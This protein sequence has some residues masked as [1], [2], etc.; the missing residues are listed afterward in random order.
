MIASG[1]PHEAELV[2]ALLEDEFAN[3]TVALTDGAIPAKGEPL[4]FGVLIL[5]YKHLAAAEQAY[6]GLLRR[7]EI[8]D[9]TMHRSVVFCSREEVADTYSLC[10]QG[11][12]DD[13]VVFWPA[14]FDIKRL[15]MAVH[16]ALKQ[17]SAVDSGPA[18][19]VTGCDSNAAV[20][21][22]DSGTQRRGVLIVDDD[23]A[24]RKLTGRILAS[25]GYELHHAGNGEEALG[26]L[27]TLR[28]DL[29]LLDLT[30]PGMGGL[31]LMRRLRDSPRNAALPVIV[32]TGN[33][34]TEIVRSSLE[35]GAV[36]F[37]VK[38]FDRSTLLAKLHRVLGSGASRSAGSGTG[39]VSPLGDR[40]S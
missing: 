35:L 13:Y 38:P 1:D 37:L 10:R 5:V 20:E 28:P 21:H 24:H 40:S 31:E 7:A 36:D 11:L 23:A 14:G 29:M 25:A 27:A 19:P 32:M 12:F 18:E 15:P 4:I 6:I 22:G 8:G 16:C 30:M 3:V 39:D 9:R 34:G 17:L 2:R 33:A 26:V